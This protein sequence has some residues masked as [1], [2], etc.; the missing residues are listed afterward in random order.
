MEAEC[1]RLIFQSL[2]QSFQ[3][4]RFVNAGDRKTHPWSCVCRLTHKER[5]NL[6]AEY[7]TGRIHSPFRQKHF[8][9]QPWLPSHTVSWCP[10]AGLSGLKG[11]FASPG[12][13]S[14]VCLLIPAPLH[15][16]EWLMACLYSGGWADWNIS[17]SHSFAAKSPSGGSPPLGVKYWQAGGRPAHYPQIK[18]LS[19]RLRD[20]HRATLHIKF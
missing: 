16:P 4:S 15:L 7:N 10:S 2:L 11:N 19:L 12:L 18:Y 17:L 1:E 3:W 13:H 20:K 14:G 9:S 5:P 8:P 6:G